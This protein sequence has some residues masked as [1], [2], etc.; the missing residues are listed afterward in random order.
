MSSPVEAWAFASAL[1]GGGW[2][3]VMLLGLIAT[4]RDFFQARVLMGAMSFLGLALLTVGVF[5][6]S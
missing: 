4:P 5:G 1:I 3:L 2:F 6:L